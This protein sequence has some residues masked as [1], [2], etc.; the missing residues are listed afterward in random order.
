MIFRCSLDRGYNGDLD[1]PHHRARNTK[2]TAWEAAGSSYLYN[3]SLEAPRDPTRSP[4]LPVAT[5]QRPRGIIARKTEAWVEHPDRFILMH[6]P[7]AQSLSKYLNR[8]HTVWTSH[9]QQWH[10][11]RIRTDFRDP[12]IAPALFVAPV[13]FVDGHAALHD[14][15]RSLM[16]DPW[17]PYEETKDWQWYQPR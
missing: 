12:R 10:R 9:W 5:L 17:Y 14:F 1:W 8:S 4:P 6:E 15:S 16:T 3:I 2:P 11:Y 13:L 7:P